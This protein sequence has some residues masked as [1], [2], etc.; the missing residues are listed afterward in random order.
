MNYWLNE[1]IKA[2]PGAFVARSTTRRGSAIL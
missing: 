1:A 2:I